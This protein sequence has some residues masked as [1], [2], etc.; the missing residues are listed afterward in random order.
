VPLIGALPKALR[1]S[2]EATALTTVVREIPN[3]AAIRAFGT[4]S[5]ASRRINAQSSKVI[6]LQSSSVHFSSVVDRPGTMDHAVEAGAQRVRDHLRR[7]IPGRRYLL[8][9]TAGNTVSQIDPAAFE[10]SLGLSTPPA[11]GAKIRAADSSERRNG[12]VLLAAVSGRLVGVGGPAGRSGAPIRGRGSS[13]RAG[14]MPGISR[15]R[16]RSAATSS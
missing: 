12:E 7:P 1:V 4:P 3:R 6:T 15:R 14:G 5:P 2:S 8:M 10:F 9:E 13:L 11:I 16:R